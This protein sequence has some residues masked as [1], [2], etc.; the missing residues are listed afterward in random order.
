[1]LSNMAMEQDRKVR[2]DE[3][4]SMGKNVSPQDMESTLQ[5]AEANYIKSLD[6]KKYTKA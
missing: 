3:I 5:I 2:F 1:M 4:D 6:N